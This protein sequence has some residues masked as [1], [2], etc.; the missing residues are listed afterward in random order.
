MTTQEVKGCCPLDCQDSCS[1]IA[2]V[3]EGRVTKVKGAKD[4]PFTRGVLCAKVYDYQQR[5]YSPDRL[6]H[7]LRRSGRKGD[8]VFERISWDEAITTIADRFNEIINRDGSEALMPLHFMGSAG[9][10][11][12]RALM[13]LFHAINASRIHGSV[14]GAAGNAIA[15]DGHPLG[16]DPEDIAQSELI[17]LWGANILSTCHHHWHFCQLAKKNNGAR[18]IAID[19]RKTRTAECCDSHLAIRPGTDT[20]LAAGIAHILLDKGLADLNFARRATLDLDLYIAEVKP[21]TPKLVAEVC[22]LPE[23]DI[24]ELAVAFGKARPAT[25]RSGIGIQQTID[26]DM[27]M[28]SISA[29]SILSGHGKSKGGGLFIEAYPTISDT[30]AE[31]VDLISS[32]PRSLNLAKIGQILTDKKMSPPINGL[33]V[34]GMNPAIIQTDLDTVCRGLARD[35][36]FCVVLEH[37]MTDTARYADIVL[38]STT[39]LEHFDIQGAWGHHYISANNQAIEPL[40]ET[41]NHGEIMRLL[42]AKMGLNHPA[43]HE[44]DQEIAASVLPDTIALSELM[45]KGWIKASPNK[46][47][48]AADGAK[49]LNISSGIP[50]PDAKRLPGDTPDD[51]LRLLTPKAH[52]FLN[53]SF[54]NMERQRK[55]QDIPILQMNT[56]D[57]SSR[58]LLDGTLVTVSNDQASLSL[59]LQLTN[60]I[61]SG[62]IS[63]E[64]KWWNKPSETA[65][66]ANRLSPASWTEVGQPAYNDIFVDVRQAL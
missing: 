57:A 62:T 58:G 47:D 50:A 17:I 16:F 32:T 63:L 21:W 26:G 64:G 65:A 52:F 51:K 25:I 31:R 41:K 34:W 28:H 39:Q 48:L 10:V 61:R 13:R 14:C 38:P 19:P 46:P 60:K 54:A 45:K 4:H 30:S 53:S 5:T 33:M 40:G 1:W 22:G 15:N 29:L 27:F 66:I 42:A 55:N 24:V 56:N 37:F 36:L 6:L 49:K 9:V 2:H 8:G 23:A 59:T 35:D 11:Q 3:E 44:S 43:L 18:I 20:I 12:R 7:P